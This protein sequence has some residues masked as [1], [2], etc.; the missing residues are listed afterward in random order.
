[1]SVHQDGRSQASEAPAGGH[2]VLPRATDGGS[3]AYSAEYVRYA[4]EQRVRWSCVCAVGEEI[5]LLTKAVEGGPLPDEIRAGWCRS[6]L[7]TAHE[8]VRDGHMH[9]PSHP[10][11]VDQVRHALRSGSPELPYR[12]WR[13]FRVLDAMSRDHVKH[14]TQV[15]RIASRARCSPR[16]PR[17]ELGLVFLH[18]VSSDRFPMAFR[19]V[20][21]CAM[22]LEE[23]QD[24]Y[25]CGMMR[26]RHR[27]AYLQK[28]DRLPEEKEM[29][30]DLLSESDQE[31][32]L[33]LNATA[34]DRRM[35]RA[36]VRGGSYPPDPW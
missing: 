17:F 6:R 16:R 4:V 27:S 36:I 26:L 33:L 32:V 34:G 5:E 29:D 1:M 7:E 24:T 31:M 20:L 14:L 35:A 19:C 25:F 12:L 13:C 18:S 15:E 21:N 28:M 11:T 10:P 9:P 23:W 2:S 30:L 22:C 3:P 8:L